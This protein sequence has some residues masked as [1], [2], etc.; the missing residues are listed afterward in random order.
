MEVD[1]AEDVEQELYQLPR[2]GDDDNDRASGYSTQLS[3][4]DVHAGED[5]YG[6]V[7]ESY[8]G[9]ATEETLSDTSLPTSVDLDK[10]MMIKDVGFVL[11]STPGELDA[12]IDALTGTNLLFIDCEGLQL[13]AQDGSLSLINIARQN[14]D[15]WVVDALTLGREA[16][17]P[18]FAVLA[19]E[20][21]AK[22]MF[23]AR[24]DW[25]EHL[26]RSALL[27]LFLRSDELALSMATAWRFE[28]SSTCSSQIY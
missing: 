27:V 28:A 21:V 6:H 5:L 2:G 19:D 20:N 9:L 16:L 7:P 14:D 12:C 15:V 13:G 10:P 23:D 4:P 26:V 17:E 1:W 25:S 8:D 22:V 3:D 18:L 11:V 24:M